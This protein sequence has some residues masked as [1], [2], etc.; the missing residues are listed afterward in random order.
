M[1]IAWWGSADLSGALDDL[2]HGRADSATA[3]GLHLALDLVVASVFIIRALHRWAHHHDDHQRWILAVFLLVVL[4]TTVVIGLREVLFRHSE[5]RAL[6][7]LRTMILRRNRDEPFQ[8]LAVVSPS[9]S[10]L[11]YDKTW[12]TSNRP[13]PGGRLRFILRTALPDLPQRDLNSV[14]GLFSLP[15]GQRLIILAGTKQRLSSA[16]QSRLGLEAIHPGRSGILDAYATARHRL[17][18]R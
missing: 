5:T 10:G 1:S 17:S 11:V 6:L 7:S 8:M 2:I 13:L 12:L 14:E 9:S 4:A 18:H 16:D 3:L 15:D